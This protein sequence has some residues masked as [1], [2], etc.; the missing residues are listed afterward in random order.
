MPSSELLSAF[1]HY[2]GPTMNAFDAAEAAGG[3]D[4]LQGELAALFVSQNESGNPGSSSIP[5]T[6][7]LVTVMR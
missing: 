7:L 4:A 6:F 5:A 2:Y 3:A 1:R